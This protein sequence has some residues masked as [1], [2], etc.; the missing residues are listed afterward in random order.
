MVSTIFGAKP[1]EARL[2]LR[3]LDPGAVGAERGDDLGDDARERPLKHPIH[4]RAR[5]RIAE[6]QIE[7][8]DRI[9]QNG[10]ILRTVGAFDVE[11]GGGP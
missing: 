7:A 10:R 8:L 5:L 6:D 9:E 11:R 2:P 4:E 1:G 3:G